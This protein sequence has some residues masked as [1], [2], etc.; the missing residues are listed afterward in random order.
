MPL[1]RP[2]PDCWRHFASH[3][4]VLQ[5]ACR[6]LQA[7]M[8]HTLSTPALNGIA[9]RNTCRLAHRLETVR[10]FFPCRWCPATSCRRCRT[11]STRSIP[12]SCWDR[13]P[14]RPS[15]SL[16]LYCCCSAPS[17]WVLATARRAAGALSRSTRRAAGIEKVL[18]HALR[19]FFGGRYLPVGAG[20]GSERRHRLN[21]VRGQWLGVRRAS[22]IGANPICRPSLRACASTIV[23]C[24]PGAVGLQR[25]RLR[26]RCQN[27]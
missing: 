25:R 4:Q 14:L 6:S 11:H 20:G 9:F 2:R 1:A 8:G 27:W 26:A 3:G 19:T 15:L 5:R 12:G 13:L 24:A 18:Q 23:P 17:S 22:W 21:P 16:P 7:N 10:H